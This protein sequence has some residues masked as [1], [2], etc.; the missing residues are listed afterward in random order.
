MERDQLCFGFVLGIA[1]M[2]V[3]VINSLRVSIAAWEAAVHSKGVAQHV[4]EGA[5]YVAELG[6]EAT[7]KTCQ[8]KETTKVANRAGRG[9]R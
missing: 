3:V 2:G 8:A 9:P 6:N 5:G 1:K 7:V 4:G